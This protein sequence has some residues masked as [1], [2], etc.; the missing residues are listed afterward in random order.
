MLIQKLL[1]IRKSDREL[2]RE[3][4]EA[5]VDSLFAPFTSLLT[6]AL[7]GGVIG[8]AVSWR[9]QDIGISLCSFAVFLV[10][11][12][13]VVLAR[14][15]R[16]H[17]EAGRVEAVEFWE[18]MYESGAWAFS[19]LLGLMCFVTVL[20]S[21]DASIHLAVGA[22]TIGYAAGI[23]GRNAGRP[24]MA[25]AQVALSSLPLGLAMFLYGDAFHIVLGCVVLCFVIGMADITVA[26]REVIIQALVNTRE[27]AMLAVKY[28]EQANLFDAALNNMSHGLCM[29]DRNKKLLVWNERFLE[30]MALPPGSV[31]AGASAREILRRCLESGNRP[32]LSTRR[33]MLYIQRNLFRTPGS[34]YEI[35]LP[36]Q[37]IIA[38]SQR[39]MADGGSVVIFE[40]ISERKRAEAKLAHMA[41]YD[42][43][44][45]LANRETIHRHVRE[46]LAI[47]RRRGAQ[48]AI[49]LIDLDRFKGINDSLGHPVGDELLNA[50]GTRLRE[51][52]GAADMVARF[53]GDEFVVLQAPICGSVE[54][55]DLAHRMA[56]A[57][58]RPF[59][60]REHQIHIGGSIG[61]AMT[62]EAGLEVEELIKHADMAM[63]A[64]KADGRGDFRV[65]EP[66]MAA[67]AQTRRALEIDLRDAISRR[68]LAVRY[69]PLVN[70]QTGRI[71][72]CEAL[73]RW[74]HPERGNIPPSVFI[75]IAEETGL[76]TGITEWV[77]HQACAE[78]V[79]WPS[80]VKVAV[81]LS[82]V[83]F[84]DANLPLMVAA[85]LGQSRLAPQRLELEI[86]ETALLR[87]TESTL[88]VLT[89]L[90]QLGVSMSLDDFG[91]GYSSL[92]YLRKFPFH[93]IKIDASFIQD[94]D[95]GED[96]TAIIRAVASMG[97]N[98]G[99]TIVA[100]G[101]ETETQL[102]RVRSEG[103]TEGQGYLLGRPML[104]DEIR[105]RLTNGRSAALM[106]A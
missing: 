80:G 103:C 22:T 35:T 83:H 24:V 77:L 55:T 26:I 31:K 46:A 104:S 100:E 36:G 3:M 95:A 94:I 2:P 21:T 32:S 54:A 96:A 19:A 25:I 5:L 98:L 37:R 42:D 89:Q 9:S 49:H 75:P 90:R 11:V 68:E 23:T 43:L 92:S 67:A 33:L 76:I 69:Q 41:Q 7:A 38:L 59:E 61:V 86:T 48:L 4:Q 60:I 20:R 27:K 97:A 52:V 29:F 50:V 88:S 47:T 99:M 105:A 57:L 30:L 17:R 8:A 40:D 45:G 91:T 70:L 66:G 81:N 71:S 16:R 84:R 58:A 18:R 15:Y 78:A 79:H 87:N 63:Y 62:P 13:R 64:A 12:A 56:V 39:L 14:K 65:F 74:S 101:I 1:A 10:G 72:G 44:T 82:P 6:G 102:E 73:L 106:V 51:L 34:A 85:A 93:K 28:E 53:G